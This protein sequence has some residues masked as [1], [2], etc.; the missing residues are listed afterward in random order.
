[1]LVIGISVRLLLEISSIQ[2]LPSQWIDFVLEFTQ[3][4][5]D[6]DVFMEPLII[7]LVNGKKD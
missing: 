4:D 7:I 6:V 1:M 2:K 5:L 3:T